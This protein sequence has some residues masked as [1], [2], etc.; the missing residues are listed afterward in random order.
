MFNYKYIFNMEK[1]KVNEIIKLAILAYQIEDDAVFSIVELGKKLH[2]SQKTIT[3]SLRDL[4]NSGELENRC[5]KG[6][7]SRYKLNYSGVCPSF[8]Y[9]ELTPGQKDFLIRV[10]KVLNGN[11]SKLTGKALDKL[12]YPNIKDHSSGPTSSTM[13]LIKKELGKDIF[14]VVKEWEP[15]KL[16]ISYDSKKGSIIK[17]EN[18]YKYLSTPEDGIEYYCQYCGE[19]D[20]SKFGEY[21]KTCKKCQSKR[22]N[23]KRK[24]NIFKFLYSKSL[25]GYRS[26]K[27]IEN[28]ELTPEIIKEV[29]ENQKEKDYY[30][31][32]NIE[33]PLD[34]SIDRIDSS[35]GYTKDNICITKI[36]INI[37]KNDLSESEFV[38]MCYEVAKHYKDIGKLKEM[39]L[40]NNS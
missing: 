21:H 37:S 16:S 4:V 19:T 17:D 8:I 30:T 34:M 13:S 5:V 20:P 1:N 39:V 32:E 40:G 14:T 10:K 15:I 29:W 2:F 36:K 12:L 35:K 7:Y 33:D 27:N 3:S 23:E 6:Y 28:Y 24:E 22:A 38:K 26:R 31:G 9:S 25:S 11:Y 18:G